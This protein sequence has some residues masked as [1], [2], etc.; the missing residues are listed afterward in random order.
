ML[1]N[2]RLLFFPSFFVFRAML[3]CISLLE[4]DSASLN[5]KK[6]MEYLVLT[7]HNKTYRFS[8]NS[9]GIQWLNTITRS[10]QYLKKGV[11][12]SNPI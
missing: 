6:G 11:D 5:S 12:K 4:I 3:L 1:T 2:R 8:L 10:Q 7:Y 9:R